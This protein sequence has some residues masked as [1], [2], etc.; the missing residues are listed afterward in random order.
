M[1]AF[2][3]K[4]A[5]IVFVGAL[6]I[7]A[8]LISLLIYGVF[9]WHI[10]QPQAWQGGL[11]LL[12]LFALIYMA[13]ANLWGKKR[14]IAISILLLI[15]ARHQAVDLP[16][17]VLYLYIESIFALG[18]HLIPLT[19]YTR[20][21][22]FPTFIVS[23]LLGVI[24]WSLCIWVSSISG[25]GTAIELRWLALAILGVALVSSN[26]PRLA[27]T[28]ANQ[29]D[30]SGKSGAVFHAIAIT[31]FVLLFAKTAVSVDYDSMW[32]GLSG[33]RV[34]V[35]SGN[36]FSSEGL[37]AVVHYYPKLYE[38]LLIPLTGIGSISAISGFSVFSW[39]LI[40]S[41]VYFILQEAGVRRKLRPV[42]IALI[43][44]LPAL[45]NISITAKGDV[46]ATWL[47]CVGIYSLLRFRSS[48]DAYW[49]WLCSSAALI[50]TQARLSSIPYAGVL[51]IVLVACMSVAAHQ[52]NLRFIKDV[53]LTKGA[54]IFVASI[55]LTVLVTLRSLKLAGIPIV[56][57]NPLVKIAELFGLSLSFPVGRLPYSTW[58]HLSVGKT[59]FFYL[60][61]PRHYSHLELY[62]TGNFWLFLP[63]IA[64]I[65]GV[66][67][68][69]AIQRA[70]PLALMGM[71]FFVVLFGFR[72]DPRAGADGNY[73]IFPLICMALFGAV[74]VQN[75]VQRQSLGAGVI[76]FILF[77]FAAS[78]ALI[79]LITGSW[80][81]GTRAFDFV[82]NRNPLDYARRQKDEIR[83]AH[84][85]G[86]ASFFKDLPTDVRVIGVA[87]TPAAWWLSVRYEPIDII[88]WSRHDFFASVTSLITYLNNDSIRYVLL[89]S[90][91]APAEFK[92]SESTILSSAIAT[93]AQRN[94]AKN[95]YTDNYYQVW[96]I[97]LHSPLDVPSLS[98]GSYLRIIPTGNPGCGVTVPFTATVN[99]RIETIHQNS[100]KIY[101]EAASSNKENL[102]A[103]LGPKGSQV[104]GQWVLPGS[105][106]LIRNAKDSKLILSNTVMP[107]CPTGT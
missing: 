54:F 9:S 70:W 35:G 52:K 64:A 75:T 63:L 89:R 105:R 88:S 42:I 82:M 59:L 31:M 107:E 56:A 55:A 103:E 40:L 18:W 6:F 20:G 86:L 23:G 41:T 46:F 69:H 29:I 61:D 1:K 79:C 10:R 104:T 67:Y 8:P 81:P 74:M 4:S 91:N 44:T 19:G 90:P 66:R 32:Y 92:T 45:A 37:V 49:L 47:L 22:G 77:L 50:A 16:I 34:L 33:D 3:I 72:F 94:I 58:Q 2:H 57:P 48:R 38:A 87:Q 65:F 53:L 12:A 5:L 14:W 60:F 100:V 39:L 26:G 84:L 71:T 24:G 73:F 93:M 17:I 43:A 25:F 30:S 13:L 36:L 76:P 99:W 83:S 21:H 106:F 78:S 27:R 95:V 51:L 102:W 11:E 85:D 28:L 80:G 15:Y 7:A 96:K 68:N 98:N 97:T 62:W 101:V